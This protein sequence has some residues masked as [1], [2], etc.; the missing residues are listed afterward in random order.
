M[1]RRVQ[2]GWYIVDE[3]QRSGS[4]FDNEQYGVVQGKVAN[5]ST[6]PRWHAFCS[7]ALHNTRW[8]AYL[9][10]S[11]SRWLPLPMTLTLTKTE[12]KAEAIEWFND[13]LGIGQTN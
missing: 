12:T 11:S 3:R 4:I 6:D 2:E 8:F 9:T 13:E 7:D 10:A 1:A 5:E